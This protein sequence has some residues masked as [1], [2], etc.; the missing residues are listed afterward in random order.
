M[1]SKRVDYE[2]KPKISDYIIC[3]AYYPNYTKL[4]N[5]TDKPYSD[6]LKWFLDREEYFMDEENDYPTV[7]KIASD[8]GISEFKAKSSLKSIYEDIFE[9]NEKSPRLFMR[10]GQILCNMSFK[11][12][13]GKTCTFNMGLDVLPRDGDSVYFLFLRATFDSWGFHVKGVYHELERGKHTVS[14]SLSPER[15]NKY[16]ELLKEKGYLRGEISFEE[17]LK[18]DASGELK[19]KLLRLYQNL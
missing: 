11:S 9:L 13:Y 7:K 15:K 3:L 19:E 17:Y 12:H 14:V 16:F 1:K 8:L 2:H 18:S 5:P 4:L 10:E 6:V